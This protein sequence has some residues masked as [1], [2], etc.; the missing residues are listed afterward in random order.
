MCTLFNIRIA[1]VSIFCNVSTF[2]A[3]HIKC[4]LTMNIMDSLFK[5]KNRLIVGQA[6]YCMK[7][8]M[9]WQKLARKFIED[10]EKV[11]NS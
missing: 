9:K 2:F 5:K 8:V 6:R 7:K 3:K 4:S 1:F 11:K 10:H